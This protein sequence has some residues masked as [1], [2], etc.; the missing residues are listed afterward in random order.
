VYGKKDGQLRNT[1]I[2]PGG[3][4]I[5]MNR[6]RDVGSAKQ[7]FPYADRRETVIKLRK[8]LGLSQTGLSKTSGLSVSLINQFECGKRD[9]SERSQ[10]MVDEALSDGLAADALHVLR[11]QR[12]QGQVGLMRD[13]GPPADVLGRE[14]LVRQKTASLRQ[15]T[16]ENADLHDHVAALSK[17]VKTM[18]QLI[19]LLKEQNQNFHEANTL[20][21]EAIRQLQALVPGEHGEVESLLKRSNLVI[22]KK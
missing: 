16:L 21:S 14:E 5:L 19:D 17:Q 20:Q 22:G 3:E 11:A 15:L 6:Q 9:F 2:R 7:R 10:R 8:Q 18:R 13:L 4:K 1:A 12:L